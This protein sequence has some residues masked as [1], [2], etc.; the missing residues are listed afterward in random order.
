MK[1][2]RETGER[3]LSKD[4]ILSMV[5]QQPCT[6]GQIARSCAVSSN[7]VVKLLSGMVRGGQLSV[8]SQG[9]RL[10]VVNAIPRIQKRP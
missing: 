2:A 6:I 4:V 9:D 8:K 7:D 10:L 1:T 3:R 5:R